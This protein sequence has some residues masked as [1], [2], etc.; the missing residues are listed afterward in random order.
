MR[1]HSLVV[2]VLS[3]G[4]CVLAACAGTQNTPTP[5]VKFDGLRIAGARDVLPLAEV[6]LKPFQ[7]TSSISV[8]LQ[9][10]SES[11]ADLQAGRADVVI[12]GREP[13]PDELA[14]LQD[15]VIA[16]DAVVGLVST[17]VYSG[18]IYGRNDVTPQVWT[19]RTD[20]L[21]ELAHTEVKSLLASRLRLGSWRWLGPYFVF[22]Q[23]RDPN[24]PGD[25]PL[26]NPI[27][28]TEPSGAW[29]RQPA[30]L[31]G[32]F[33]SPG[34]Y[35]TQ[36]VLL[37]TFGFDE[38]RLAVQ[39]TEID[40]YQ[41]HFETEEELLASQ[42][43]YGIDRNEVVSNEPFFFKLMFVSRRVAKRALA[44]GF[45][46]RTIAIDGVNPSD[47]AAIYDGTYRLS[48][49]IHVLTKKNPSKD[50]QAFVSFLK[51]DAGQSAVA[52]AHFL[53]LQTQAK[54]TP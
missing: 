22:R 11:V 27:N 54:I 9:T 10:S 43:A 41:K 30:P 34:A 1:K 37:E 2:F 39:G 20:G 16:Y 14:D 40:F 7:Q 44:Y 33:A 32:S 8:S 21:R 47:P 17:R 3:I 51:T 28:P 12:L 6:A 36:R 49:K 46:V 31:V 13:R 50:A 25:N 19:S 38:Q 15:Q 52:R 24:I 35:D 45:L 53:P 5:V 23:D 4:M 29:L 48:R 18:G 26:P 42:F